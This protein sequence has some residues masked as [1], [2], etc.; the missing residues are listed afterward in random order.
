MV[1]IVFEDCV[2]EVGVGFGYVVVVLF[3]FVD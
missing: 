3:C 2:F 1:G